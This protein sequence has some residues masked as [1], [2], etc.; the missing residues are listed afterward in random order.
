MSNIEEMAKAYAFE[1]SGVDTTDYDLKKLESY[2]T[3][4]NAVLREIEN[5]LAEF[6][7]TE[8][9]SILQRKI[10]ELKGE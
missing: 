5:I 4:A 7:N 10:K 6:S 9:Y 1:G 8:D 3:G 2:I